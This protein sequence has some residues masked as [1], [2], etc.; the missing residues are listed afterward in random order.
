MFVCSLLRV[1]ISMAAC[2]IFI[3]VKAPQSVTINGSKSGQDKAQAE[4]RDRQKILAQNEKYSNEVKNKIYALRLKLAEYELGDINF[5][6]FN[7]FNT[8][9]SRMV[10]S[11]KDVFSVDV[12][13]F[14]EKINRLIFFFHKRSASQKLMEVLYTIKKG[15]FAQLLQASR[16]NSGAKTSQH[17]SVRKIELDKRTCHFIDLLYKDMLVLKAWNDEPVS[18]SKPASILLKKDGKDLAPNLKGLEKDLAADV[19]VQLSSLSTQ[20]IPEYFDKV[21]MTLCLVLSQ[22]LGKDSLIKKWRVDFVRGGTSEGQVSVS[23]AIRSGDVLSISVRIAIDENTFFN[24]EN[25]KTVLNRIL[26]SISEAFFKEVVSFEYGVP[27]DDSSNFFI[28]LAKQFAENFYADNADSQSVNAEKK[29]APDTK[30][31]LAAMQNLFSEDSIA[32]SSLD[33]FDQYLYNDS[34]NKGTKEVDLITIEKDFSGEPCDDFKKHVLA[35]KN[36]EQES[37]IFEAA[38]IIRGVSEEPLTEMSYLLRGEKLLDKRISLFEH[39]AEPSLLF[40]KLQQKDEKPLGK[41]NLAEDFLVVSEKEEF[42][43]G[44]EYKSQLELILYKLM[45]ADSKLKKDFGFRTV[46]ALVK[47][48]ETLNPFFKFKEPSKEMVENKL[49]LKDF[50][51][52]LKSTP[53]IKK[54]VLQQVLA[55]LAVLSDES[56]MI[57]EDSFYKVC[58]LKLL[59]MLEIT[60]EMKQQLL[61]FFKKD[62]ELFKK[63]SE[64]VRSKISAVRDF[65]RNLDPNGQIKNKKEADKAPVTKVLVFDEYKSLTRNPK[66]WVYA[67]AKNAQIFAQ[68]WSAPYVWQPLSERI[69]NYQPILDLDRYKATEHDLNIVRQLWSSRA[70]EKTSLEKQ[71]EALNDNITK[72]ETAI[73]V[74]NQLIASKNTELESLNSELNITPEQKQKASLLTA[75][76]K[77]KTVEIAT[78]NDRIAESEKQKI[79]VALKLKRVIADEGALS[80]KVA[81]LEKVMKIERKEYVTQ[82]TAAGQAGQNAYVDQT[83]PLPNNSTLSQDLALTADLTLNKDVALPNNAFVLPERGEMILGDDL[84]LVSVLDL[85][86]DE[87][88]FETNSYLIKDSRVIVVDNFIDIEL[89]SDF[90]VVGNGGAA[91]ILPKGTVLPAGKKINFLVTLPKDIKLKSDLNLGTGCVLPKNM[92]LTNE[93][94]RQLASNSPNAVPEYWFKNTNFLKKKFEIQLAPAAQ[95]PAPAAL[96]FKKG[97]TLPKGLQLIDVVLPEAVTLDKEI[98]LSGREIIPAQTVLPIKLEKGLVMTDSYQLKTNLRLLKPCTMKGSSI[99]TMDAGYRKPFLK[100]QT[101]FAKG[102]KIKAGQSDWEINSFIKLPEGTKLP[103]GFIF[104]EGIQLPQGLFLPVGTN[105]PVIPKSSWWSWSK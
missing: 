40:D 79:E 84:S 16:A 6:L 14:L 38:P 10:G 39:Q 97:H 12:L 47:N 32:S 43:E 96:T 8:P 21:V 89:D 31:F 83:Y 94:K 72:K 57:K 67:G 15:L 77:A 91:G 5:R 28:K 29:S 101:L 26:K 44:K 11:L 27:K 63:L 95:Q 54:R 66:N 37:K 71:M 42:S 13:K 20:Y 17:G 92:R 4:M 3:D 51:E 53:S 41:T 34:N 62:N 24:S 48:Y 86:V 69:A 90:Q 102:S 56:F 9:E 33:Q 104:K 52:N 50:L 68:K 23:S 70:N 93:Q 99:I 18:K 103:K 98:S 30:Q 1:I 58:N 25:Y 74:I 2:L 82:A 65:L 45:P 59:S 7:I 36:F 76:I 60:R 81:A 73:K 87:I 61:N 49:G 100:P 80:A 75:D 35:V 88:T 64:D 55:Y 22:N 105:V 19:L 85:D 78:L 46:Y